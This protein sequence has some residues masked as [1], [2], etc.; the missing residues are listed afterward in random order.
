MS[1]YSLT[2]AQWTAAED[3]KERIADARDAVDEDPIQT[4]SRTKIRQSPH[5]LYD[6]YVIFG[7][8]TLSSSCQGLSTKDHERTFLS[9]GTSPRLDRGSDSPT[10]ISTIH[11]SEICACTQWIR[12]HTDCM[13]LEKCFRGKA[14]ESDLIHTV[15]QHFGYI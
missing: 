15:A 8:R 1:P 12:L 13:L 4:I 7:P 9:L 14:G 3:G 10:V 2:P 5:I 6:L 11:N